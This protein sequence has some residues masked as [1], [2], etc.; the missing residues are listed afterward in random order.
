MDGHGFVEVAWCQGQFDAEG[1]LKVKAERCAA[2]EGRER[3]ANLTLS[4]QT[5]ATES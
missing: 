2:C 4:D 3:G 5:F 1:S